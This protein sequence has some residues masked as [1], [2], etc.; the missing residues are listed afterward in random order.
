MLLY[1]PNTSTL[2]YHR[3]RV[4]AIPRRG[5]ICCETALMSRIFTIANSANIVAILPSNLL[6]GLAVK[7]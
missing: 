2:P 3:K 4:L 5:L 1:I 6:E 7:V